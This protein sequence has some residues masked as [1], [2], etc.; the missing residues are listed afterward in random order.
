MTYGLPVFLMHA[1]RFVSTLWTDTANKGFVASNSY[2]DENFAREVM[3]RAL[4]HLNPITTGLA[5]LPA[6]ATAPCTP[7][8]THSPTHRVS[9]C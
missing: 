4:S 6:L 1:S 7:F 2:P 9:L 3:Q 8:L 5:M